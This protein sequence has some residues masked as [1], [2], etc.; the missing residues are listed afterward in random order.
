MSLILNP[1]ASTFK[2]NPLTSLNLGTHLI[3]LLYGNADEPQ[4]HRR[5]KLC[6]KVLIVLAL[7]PSFSGYCNTNTV[8]QHKKPKYPPPPNPRKQLKEKINE[9]KN[10]FEQSLL[11]KM[12]LKCYIRKKK[13]KK[14]AVTKNGLLAKS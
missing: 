13:K 14:V 7:C 8:N 10:H 2:L 4:P 12:L 3:I 11:I 1:A 9:E 6:W 5:R